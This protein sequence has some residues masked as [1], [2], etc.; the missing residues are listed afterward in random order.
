MAGYIDSEAVF[1]QRCRGIGFDLAEVN[2]IFANHYGTMGRYAYSCSYV[3]GGSN[4][5][6][7]AKV[8]GNDPTEPGF[9]GLYRRLFYEAFTLVQADLKSKVERSSDDMPAKKLAVPERAAR[10]RAQVIRLGSGINLRGDLE[11]ADS[12]IDECVSQFEENRLKYIKWERCL[13]RSL[14]LD[15]VK[16]DTRIMPHSDL[17]LLRIGKVDVIEDTDLSS[18]LAIKSALARRGLAY[19]Q[20]SL[21]SFEKHRDWVDKLFYKRAADPLRGHSKVTIEQLEVADRAL[22][23]RLAELCRDGIV[24]D[25]GGIRP[26]DTAIEKAMDE[27]DISHLL[28]QLPAREGALKRHEPDSG[29]DDRSDSRKKHKGKG[30]GKGKEK[31]K[32]KGAGKGSSSQQLPGGLKGSSRTPDGASICFN[33]KLKKCEQNKNG[34]PRGKHVCT[35]CFGSHPFSE[36]SAQ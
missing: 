32:A 35:K 14:E 24:P 22:F 34:C 6:A 16:R 33:F 11:C 20:A 4:D 13:K 12:L 19:D 7:V 3:P 25:G 27:P 5:D 2:K 21:I 31:G 17:N 28:S 26:L 15:G 10:Y 23:N 29:L 18:E 1:R 8:S 36:C 30:K 9:I